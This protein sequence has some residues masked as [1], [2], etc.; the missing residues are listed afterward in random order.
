MMVPW[1]RMESV[2]LGLLEPGIILHICNGQA[3]HIFRLPVFSVTD[4]FGLVLG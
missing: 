4:D 1:I 3:G 2:L